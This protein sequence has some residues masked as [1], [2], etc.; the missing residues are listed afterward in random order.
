M[1]QQVEEQLHSSQHLSCVPVVVY[2][3]CQIH[4]Q[5][6]CSSSRLELCWSLHH[7][8]WVSGTLWMVVQEEEDAEE[9]ERNELKIRDVH[10]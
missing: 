7:Q 3:R 1:V 4:R 5:D 2:Q 8:S 6:C 9:L 10:K